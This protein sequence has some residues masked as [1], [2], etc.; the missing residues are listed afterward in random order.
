MKKLLLVLLCAGGVAGCATDAR[1]DV[2]NAHLLQIQTN[3]HLQVI[4]SQLMKLNSAEEG[5]VT[6]SP[7]LAKEFCFLDGK[8]YSKGFVETREGKNLECVE[9]LDPYSSRGMASK[10]DMVWKVSQAAEVKHVTPLV[11]RSIG[12]SSLTKHVTPVA[13]TAILNEPK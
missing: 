10:G 9:G 6:P 5:R 13:P 12:K 4:Q 11:I 3:N 1:Q 8:V 7:M 2:T